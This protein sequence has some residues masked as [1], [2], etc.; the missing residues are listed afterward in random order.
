[1]NKYPL[2]RYLLIIALVALSVIY[3]L[4]NVYG[5]DPAIEIKLNTPARNTNA[6][7]ASIAATLKKAHISA[8]A[9]EP[10]ANQILVRLKHSSQQLDAQAEISRLLGSTA[11]V[12]LNLASRTPAW[13]LHIGAQPMKLGL[14]LRGGVHFLIDV[15]THSMIKNRLQADMHAIA[16]MLRTNKLRYASIS[17]DDKALKMSIYFKSI[18][19]RD[20]AISLL[21]RDYQDYLF[22]ATAIGNAG[23]IEG[24]LTNSAINTENNYAVD[25]N[26]TI[27]NNR[28]NEL[29]IAEPVIQ[30]QGATQ[31]SVDLPGVQD[32]A[33][34]KDLIGKMATVKMQLVDTSHN[35]ETAQETGIVPFGT[36]LKKDEYQ[37]PILLKNQVILSGSS[38]INANAT[39]DE[40]GRPAVSLRIAGSAISQFNQITG[41]NIGQPM[42]VLYVENKNIMEEKGGKPVN[43]TRTIERIINVATINSALGGNFQIMGLSSM[44]Y[45]KNLA[46]L[47]RSGAYKAGMSFVQERVVGPSLGQKNIH[48]GMLSLEIGALA[49]FVFMLL[50]YRLF[51]VVA[52][53][54][55]ILNLVFIVAIQSALGATMTLAGMAALVLTVGM[56]VDANVLINERIRE[57]LR[58]GV[59]A[60]AAI[61]SGY[62]RAFSTIVDANITTLI[63]AVILLSIGSSAVQGF[64]VTLIIGLLTSMVTAIFFTRALVNLIY[65]RRR[66]ID[67]LSIGIKV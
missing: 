29:G 3:A 45:A 21:S 62:A 26:L 47:L 67:Q 37:R 16:L 18:Q 64:A 7:A 20:Q 30:R 41:E 5:E 46:V 66:R 63:V 2:W 36:S 19:N 11:T 52:N 43:T 31:I 42:A 9:I 54:A 27:L 61:A 49:V 22:K 10:S 48:M 51:G 15:D 50:Y 56:A 32:M 33:R 4:P 8:S 12:A 39:V 25:Q 60:Q 58:L 34:A 13:L 35:A 57:E 14:D 55:L 65:G 23:C 44:E 59:T 38:I 28:V 40:N 24:T 1:M 17:L 53:I 6:V